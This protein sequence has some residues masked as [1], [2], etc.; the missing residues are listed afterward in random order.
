MTFDPEQRNHTNA[1]KAQTRA[2]EKLTTAI[3][4]HDKL[5]RELAMRNQEEMDRNAR[6]YGWE[7]C[8]QGTLAENFTSLSEDNPFIN[9]NWRK[10]M[11]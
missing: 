2:T 10:D 8:R 3:E 9:P 1:V 4:N 5:T 7:A 6:A 11:V